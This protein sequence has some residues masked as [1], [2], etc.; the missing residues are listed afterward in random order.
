MSETRMGETLTEQTLARLA[1]LQREY[2]V[3]QRRLQ[4]LMAQEVSI[5]ETL[6][7]I[8][9]AIQVLLELVGESDSAAQAAA[10]P[11]AAGPGGASDASGPV[12]TTEMPAPG[13]VLR[14]D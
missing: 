6:L 2:E 5:R 3:G 11:S 8:S 9:G 7:R 12:S 4:E 13:T 1:E 14:V 10:V